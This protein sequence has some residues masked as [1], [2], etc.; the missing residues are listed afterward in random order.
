MADA[1]SRNEV[2]EAAVMR[3]HGLA[4]GRRPFSDLEAHFPR[5]C[6]GVIGVLTQ[7]V[8]HDAYARQEQMSAAARLAYHQDAS[9]PLMDELKGW[10]AKQVD[11]RLVE[12]NS[13]LG[14]A[15][16]SMQGHW[17]PLTRCSMAA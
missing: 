14:K 12:P 11:D 4:H 9:R 1:L 15:M 6:Q 3:C 16:A 13:A 17:A 10:L 5:A 8:D 2:N 7:V